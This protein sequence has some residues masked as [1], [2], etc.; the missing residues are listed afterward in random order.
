MKNKKI[1]QATFAGGC[2]WCMEFPFK[3]LEGVKDVIPGYTG[4]KT[5]NPTYDEVSSGKT[6]HREAVYITYN[7]SKTNYNQ[8]L[9]VFWKQIDPTDN[10]G[11]FTDRGNQYVPTIFYYD[12]EQRKIAE[13]SKK[14]LNKSKKFKNPILVEIRKASKFYPA[15]EYHQ[16]YAQKNPSRYNTYKIM[17]GRATFLKKTW[18]K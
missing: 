18:G 6:D 8:L 17:S 11:Q 12:E 2:F 13:K 9:D 4:G 15:E 16:N 7:P 10:Q 3:V 5:K 1:S 14:E